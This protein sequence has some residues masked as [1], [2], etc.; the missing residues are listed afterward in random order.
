MEP[1][2]TSLWISQEFM[3]IEQKM[4]KILC[5]SFRSFIQ[6]PLAFSPSW[7]H[8]KSVSFYLAGNTELH[9]R[10]FSLWNQNKSV[11]YGLALLFPESPTADDVF[12]ATSAIPGYST[13]EGWEPCTG[14]CHMHNCF[15]KLS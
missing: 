2:A 1:R 10:E 14:G 6:F 8:M 3:L 4:K 5:L 15:K 11:S 7:C 9:S 13:P 12:V